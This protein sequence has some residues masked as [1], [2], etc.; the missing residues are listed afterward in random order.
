[1]QGSFLESS[2]PLRQNL[3]SIFGRY[4]VWAR[5]GIFTKLYDDLHI[6]VLIFDFLNSPA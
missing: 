1:M 3:E 4:V 2:N 6:N 5:M